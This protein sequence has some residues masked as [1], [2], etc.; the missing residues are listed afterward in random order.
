MGI[1]YTPKPWIVKCFQWTGSNLAALED[2][3]EE[4]APALL[5]LTDNQDGT[6]TVGPGAGGYEVQT[7]SWLSDSGMYDPESMTAMQEVTGGGV[8]YLI[9]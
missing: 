1:Y 4:H 9:E 5:P 2:F 6:L 3:C 8:S 7:G